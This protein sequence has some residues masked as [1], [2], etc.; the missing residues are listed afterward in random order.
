MKTKLIFIG[1]LFFLLL[2]MPSYAQKTSKKQ[3]DPKSK[4]EKTQTVRKLKTKKSR[5]TYEI[6]KPKVMTQVPQKPKVIF[7]KLE[8]SKV[9]NMAEI[10]KQAK[11]LRLRTTESQFDTGDHSTMSSS[12]EREEDGKFCTTTTLNTRLNT[13]AFADFTTNGPPDWMKPGI[14]LDVPSFIDGAAK[15]EER[16]NRGPI[17]IATNA[18]SAKKVIQVVT[19]PRGKSQITQAI[20]DLLS[21]DR[22]QLHG[23]NINY[24]YSEIRSKDELNYKVNGRYSNSFADISVSLGMTS[25]SEKEHHYYLVEFQQVLFSLEVDGLDP[26]NIFPN[27]PGL[28]LRDYV[29]ISQVNYGRK[30]YFMFISDTSLEELGVSASASA[31]YFG[32]NASIEANLNQ[33]SQT[34]SVEIKAFYYGGRVDSAISDLI[35]D[36]DDPKWKPLKTYMQGDKFSEAEAYPISYKL[37]NLNND[38]VGMSSTNKQKIKTCISSSKNMK[39]KVTLLELQC[40]TSGDSDDRGDFGITQHV[41]Y[42]ANGGNWKTPIKTTINKFRSTC[43]PGDINRNW[44]GSTALICGNTNNQI[45]VNESNEPMRR[46]PNINNSMVFEITPQEASDKNAVFEIDTWVKEY[47]NS[48]VVMNHD[49]RKTAVAIHDVIAILKGIKSI[50]NSNASAYF[51]G[52]VNSSLKFYN[53]DGVS[54]PLRKVGDNILEGPIRARNRGGDLNQK[55]FVWMRFEIID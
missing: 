42:K 25:N 35:A 7:T 20:A 5:R 19:N 43:D 17:T 9:F 30:G 15:I 22:Y 34:E 36:R 51:D 26:T 2:T 4:T 50:D 27:N 54:L 21:E 24:S 38:P 40:D 44:T 11:R 47:S 23:A 29:Y 13:Q 39:L 8:P 16:Y 31:S 48:D 33:I 46:N 14:I 28:D 41:R 53:F 32:N 52:G 12:G 18:A 37:K 3:K 10:A 49:P 6:K 55:A 1:A 45:H